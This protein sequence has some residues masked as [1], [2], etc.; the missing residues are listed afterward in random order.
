MSERLDNSAHVDFAAQEL[1][2]RDPVLNRLISHVGPMRLR[3]ERERFRM[4]VRAILSQQISVAAAR[5][6]RKRFERLMAPHRVTPARVLQLSEEQIRSAG[7][8][9]QKARYILTSAQAVVD[10]NVRLSSLHR[11]ADADAIAELTKLLGIG[12]WTA[13]MFLMFALGR[14]DIFSIGDLGLRNA[15]TKLYGLETQEDCL[16]LAETW[17]PHR[18]I[19]SWYLWRHVDVHEIKTEYDRYPV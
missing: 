6:I 13:E 12:Q 4:L 7:V 15:V 19:A 3:L 17:A 11:M 18:S 9:R 16:K 5:T 8:T 2:K 10:G 14:T 1:A